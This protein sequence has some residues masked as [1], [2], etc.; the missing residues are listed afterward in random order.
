MASEHGGSPRQILTQIAHQIDDLSQALSN[1]GQIATV[2]NTAGG[3]VNINENVEEEVRAVFTGHRVR[4]INVNP[5][6]ARSPRTA[7]QPVLTASTASGPTSGPTPRQL[8]V[9]SPALPSGNIYTPLYNARRNFNNQRTAIGNRRTSRSQRATKARGANGPF[10]RDLIL[11]TGPGDMNV[12]RQGI[13]VFLQE[14]GHI[15]NAF[16]FMKE[17]S[18]I[19]IILQI[20][21][22]FQEKIPDGVDFEI[23]HSVHTSLLTPTLAAGQYLTGSVMSRVFRDNKPVY[24]RPSVQIVRTP[25]ANVEKKQKTSHEK[26]VED[27]FSISTDSIS[28][29]SS[30]KYIYINI[31]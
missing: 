3:A 15:I 10:S 12:P 24:V 7:V 14:Q 21:E 11:L 18:D 28:L 16:E 27:D 13:K 26:D 31:L 9:S 25:P 6:E 1:D 29:S 23:V 2:N 20:R 5:N 22:A 19:E 8:T 17:W 4:N 30:S